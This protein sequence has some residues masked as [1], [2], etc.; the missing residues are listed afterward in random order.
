[1]LAL[2]SP[3]LLGSSSVVALRWVE[4]AMTFRPDRY[5]LGQSWEVPSGAEEVSFPNQDGQRLNGW[6]IPASS[7]HAQATVIFFHGHAGNITNVRFIGEALS[8]LGLDALLFDYRGYGKS[9]G[10]IRSE[11]DMYA[12]ADAAYD[13]AVN[14]R[15]IALDKIVLYGHSLGTAAVV[16]L[17]SRKQCAGIILESGL[18]S[19]GDIASFKMPWLPAF[20]RGLSANRFD[21]ARKLASVLC[22]VLVAHGEPDSVVPTDEGRALFEA[23]PGPKELIIMPGAGHSVASFGGI[24]YFNR[25]A[26]F[27]KQ[28]LAVPT[29]NARANRE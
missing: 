27:I 9:E 6:F 4:Q 28:S 22:P 12:D 17:A 13:Y 23:A 2:L 26:S 11:R 24:G 18:S 10:E 15:G 5:I 20:L 19:A 3:V 16:D 8:A 29:A 14:G 21:S 25:L 1:V 7:G